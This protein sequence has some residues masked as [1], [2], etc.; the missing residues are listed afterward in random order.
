MEGSYLES[1]F[2]TVDQSMFLNGIYFHWEWT[3]LSHSRW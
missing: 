3:D 2:H 1:C